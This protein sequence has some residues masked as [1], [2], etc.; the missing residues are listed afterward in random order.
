MSSHGWRRHD[1]YLQAELK[2]DIATEYQEKHYSD[3]EKIWKE[4]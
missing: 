3:G 1:Q 4:H 2:A